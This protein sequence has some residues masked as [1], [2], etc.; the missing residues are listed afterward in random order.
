MVR[1]LERRLARLEPPPAE[2]KIR[3]VW[4][5]GQPDLAAQV[6]ELEAQGFN[7]IVVGW[8]GRI[9]NARS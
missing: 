4:N 6:A 8:A 9:G 3:Y 5:D 7:V 1:E 2:R